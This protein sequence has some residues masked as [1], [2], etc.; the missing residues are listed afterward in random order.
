[1]STQ[2]EINR[3]SSWE[4]DRLLQ[5]LA[6]HLDSALNLFGIN[7][8]PISNLLEPHTE[9]EIESILDEIMTPECACR[10]GDS[11]CESN[12]HGFPPWFVAQAQPAARAFLKAWKQVAK[13][14]A[15]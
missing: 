8:E 7:Q 1:M 3:M 2:R 14:P 10:K 6:S 12:G 15:D 9:R 5:S 13:S 11:S 4:R